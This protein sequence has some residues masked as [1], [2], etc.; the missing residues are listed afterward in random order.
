MSLFS[1]SPVP[2]VSAADAIDMLT[3]GA[4]LI[5]IREADE[6][7]AG[8]APMAAHIPMGELGTAAEALSRTS[9]LIFI[10]RSGRRSDHA[11][12]ALVK[13]GYNAINLAGGMQAWQQA[14]G[15]VVRDDGLTGMVI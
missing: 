15:P 13:A 5:D 8:H 7:K 6:W 14:G 9:P 1:Q 4:T 10:C 11:V 12:G 3:T 2:V